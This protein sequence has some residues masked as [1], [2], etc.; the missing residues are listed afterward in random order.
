MPI[1]SVQG[2][3]GKTYSI[4][5]PAGATDQ[6]VIGAIQ[7]DLDN[8]QYADA[9]RR[10]QEARDA[11]AAGN[12]EGGFKA[13]FKSGLE[14]TKGDVA[15]ALG[16][17]GLMDLKAAEE[18]RAGKKKEA[19][20]I[21]KPTEEG[22]TDAPWTKFKETAGGSLAAMVAPAAVGAGVAGAAALAPVALPTAAL[23]SG[24][25]GLMSLAQYTGS[26]LGAQMEGEAGKS[27]MNLADTNLFN[28]ASAG[29]LQ[30]AL[31]QV[32]LR[33]I[34][35]IGRIFKSAGKEV[36]EETLKKVAE[37]GLTENILRAGASTAA[38]ESA[39]EVGQQFLERLQ[40]DFELMSPTARD[41]YLDS[42]IGGAVLG[43]VAG[44]VGGAG[45]RGQARG[46]L[47]GI[48]ADRQIA[49]EEA[50]K[51]APGTALALTGS[52]ELTVP[53]TPSTE[54]ATTQTP[55]TFE[56]RENVPA[57][58]QPQLP[59]PQ[60]HVP[61]TAEAVQVSGPEATEG[62]VVANVPGAAPGQQ[63]VLD[64]FGGEP[65]KATE[66][67]QR[68][69]AERPKEESAAQ[70]LAAPKQA[71]DEYGRPIASLK[72]DQAQEGQG[73]LQFAPAAPEAKPQNAPATKI[74]REMGYT[75]A[76]QQREQQKQAEMDK[77]QQQS[78]AQQQLTIAGMGE[79][80]KAPPV[81]QKPIAPAEP[82][83][84]NLFGR[85]Q[86]PVPSRAEGIKKGVGTQV[87]EQ[88]PE[89]LAPIMSDAVLA[90]IGIKRNAP[91]W[92]KVEGKNLENEED[93]DIVQRELTRYAKNA[94][95]PQETKDA[96]N[97]VLKSSPFIQVQGAL[98]FNKAAPKPTTGA[99]NVNVPDRAGN[100]PKP[101][102]DSGAGKPS[103]GVGSVGV[104]KAPVGE[105]STR[106]VSPPA[107]RGLAPVSGRAKPDN[108]GKAQK[109]TV[110]VEKS[111]E[112]EKVQFPEEY[113]TIADI[114]QTIAG[115]KEL[116][117]NKVEK[118]RKHEGLKSLLALAEQDLDKAKEIAAQQ[119]VRAEKAK[120]AEKS[121]EKTENKPTNQKTET[122]AEKT[123]FVDSVAPF[124]PAN[125][126]L[127]QTAKTLEYYKNTVNPELQKYIDYYEK[128]IA[129]GQENKYTQARLD[130]ARAQLAQNKAFIAKGPTEKAKPAVNPFDVMI[131]QVQS[132]ITN[133]PEW[134]G[135]TVYKNTG[136]K[137]TKGK[138]LNL[139]ESIGEDLSADVASHLK[140]GNLVDALNALSEQS[141][142]VV[143]R[144]VELLAKAVGRTKI[145]VVD[146]LKDA[147]G[148]PVSGMFDPKVNTIF[149]DSK[150]G[151]N[152]HTLIHETVHGALSHVI[153][154]TS[155][156]VA[157][158]LRE[159][160][161]SVA[162]LLD[163]AYGASNVQE[164]VA[165]A[166]GNPEFRSKLA[167]MNPD[168]TKFSALQ[169]FMNIVKNYV[170]RML[171]METK[172][173]E[174]A[175]DKTDRLI[176]SILSVAPDTRDGASLYL[177][178]AQGKGEKV[179][180]AMG[181]VYNDL[182]LFNEK[183]KDNFHE[184]F[185]GKIPAAIKSLVR[186]A[187]PLNALADVAANFIP[188]AHQ[189]NKLIDRRSGAEGIRNR[190]IEP[191]VI[192]AKE[193]A[194]KQSTETLTAFDNVVYESTIMG[195]DPSKDRSF[196]KGKTDKSGNKLDAAWDKMQADWQRVKKSGG[197]KVYA[198]M[199]DT[200]KKMYDEIG[201][202]LE[203]RIKD[204]FGD[205]T[206]AKTA[207]DILQKL[208]KEKG[209]IEP[210]FP[211]VRRGSYWLSYNL[212]GEMY[213]EAFETKRARDR[214][215]DEVSKEG[216][217]TDI[218]RF[219]N[220]SEVNYR[221]APSSSF[222]GRVLRSLEANGIKGEAM[223]EVMRLYMDAL[224]ENS[225]AQSFRTR[226]GTLGF[227]RDAIRAFTSKTY[228][229][230]RQLANLEYGAKLNK[231]KT[232]MQEHVK[233]GGNQ[234]E[235]VA[236][237][238]E[239]AKHI[240]FAISPNIPKWSKIATSI[241]FN[242]TLGFNLSSALVNITQ[243]PLITLPY[244]GGKYGYGATSAAIGNAT[245]IYMNSGFAQ[246]GTT[247][248]LGNKVDIKSFPSLDNYDWDKVPKE[249]KHYKTLSTMAEEYG[250]LN[251]SQIYD[252]LDVDQTDNIMT[253]VNA[254]SGFVF[255]HGERMN[256]QVS[257]IAAYDLELARMK[258]KPE[259]DEK[260]MT[261]AQRE[262]RAAEN[263]I[264]VTELTNG[265]TSAAAAPSL[266]QNGIGKVLF[267][268]K[269]Y[270]VSMYY[271]MFKTA[272]EA[273][274]STDPKVRKAAMYQIA[275]VYGSAALIAGIKGVPMF[276]IAAM[277]YNLFKDDDDD[278]FEVAARK[279]M[280]ETAYSGALNGITGLEIASRVGLSDLLF[281]DPQAPE[282]Q[283][284][285]LTAMEMI[286]GPVYGVGK[287]L[288]RGISL[289][290]QGHIERGVE[291]MLPSALGNGLKAV[292]YATEGATTLRGDPI[293]GEISPWN[294]SA[295]ALGF[296]PAEYTR[297]LE[298][299]ANEKGF[300]RAVVKQR[301]QMLLEYYMA[302]KQGDSNGMQSVM[303]DMNKFNQKHP[304]IAVTGET[305]T[306]SMQ[307]HMKATAEKYHGVTLNK[308]LRPE[309]IQRLSEY[310][311]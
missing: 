198:D 55:V 109:P 101:A 307:D 155:H 65:V 255:H 204:E 246:K 264:A 29:V 14:E 113:K 140:K 248:I 283:T 67:A 252:I 142:G 216:K 272:R 37:R 221:N 306:K 253:K 192:R 53:G 121:V 217:A 280:G 225:F 90:E 257:L 8:Q 80:P 145:K 151:I 116:I 190:K 59:G 247:D 123:T 136:E 57:A 42:L 162:P 88:A 1:Y 96:I 167:A 131:A 152:S 287:K 170:R 104:G 180:E 91:V 28:A 120:P 103:V 100:A 177:A 203:G 249:L 63:G 70:K 43:G 139:E 2:P 273:L 143:K 240:N 282:S 105:E 73:A 295:Q 48:E 291:A 285:L 156:P 13:A 213:V 22:W 114:E 175:Y 160:F 17:S 118:G 299:N 258:N 61:T 308:R 5:G 269:R 158:Q 150:T 161:K 137:E 34:P 220:I 207:N 181:K 294:V 205:T 24:A 135:K 186:A 7:A 196:Y 75:A 218:Q 268:F 227:E 32:T 149:L 129:K 172:G 233:K 201:V 261:Q 115:Y 35:G 50:A 266:A 21:Y 133:P 164:F 305:I 23:A 262:T 215:V 197:D 173:I 144:I 208:Y 111:A 125:P 39:T 288:E 97:K 112:R 30:A 236:Y 276:G 127:P 10:V 157:K 187:L 174:S 271:M 62:K 60:T 126:N 176:E 11:I 244:L 277:M 171:G 193:W 188:M 303:T 9:Q 20:K 232:D 199:R 235:A 259:P 54:L 85:K 72:L 159:L 311:K 108:E 146:N 110:A 122:E 168:G 228:S 46:K 84:L 237:Y 95:V 82:T 79:E 222:M 214:A 242:M 182:P 33:L 293:T 68:M 281:R 119:K 49:A 265:G 185:Q 26:N 298:I 289:I 52:R 16:R 191:V 267:M 148:K 211:L 178:S 200:Y 189:V 87:A 58:E 130:K 92:N 81:V 31:D 38:K 3:D 290:G 99:K 51:N 93:R 12:P 94:L 166:W 106:E 56:G 309:F 44:G 69:G 27:G 292:R 300:E 183:T 71:T 19:G 226:K 124:K 260:D 40:A 89:Q 256:R 194:S 169:K 229:I 77:I 41:Q 202:I 78:E 270:G 243:I 83:Q 165:E 241:G 263:A 250:Q 206:K 230:S 141:D 45:A 209:I 286:G 74:Q 195:V 4:E 98:D 18:Y 254:A 66:L 223:E 279:W 284:V 304:S 102:A 153:D 219:K 76:E 238:D 132:G 64:I 179:F 234:E 245:R 184:F 212:D 239:L 224:P 310:D 278:S 231:L 128:L 36:S 25:A 297:Q 138:K 251:R 210:Y 6:Q 147:D 274:K 302:A 275:G 163:T 117:A 47:A 296:A 154:S 301:K 15:A 86:A 134:A 107:K